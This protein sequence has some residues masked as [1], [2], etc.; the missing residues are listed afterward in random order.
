MLKRLAAWLLDGRRGRGRPEERPPLTRLAF[1]KRLLRR[2]NGQL[3]FRPRA[4]LPYQRGTHP[5]EL[6]V[7]RIDGLDDM[8]VWEHVAKH[9]HRPGRNLHGRTDFL[10]QDLD[11][12]ILKPELDETPPRHGNIVGWPRDADDQLA[13]AQNLAEIATAFPV[14]GPEE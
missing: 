14:P 7:F 13:L 9:A 1:S 2:S 10:L 8:G 11:T 6:S 12:S 3:Q 4:F 5:P